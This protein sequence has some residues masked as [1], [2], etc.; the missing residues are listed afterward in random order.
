MPLCDTKMWYALS[1]PMCILSMTN[2]SA[3]ELVTVPPPLSPLTSTRTQHCPPRVC[4]L[5]YSYH[6]DTV[7][8]PGDLLLNPCHTHTHTEHGQ[9]RLYNSCPAHSFIH[10]L[11]DFRKISK[12][13]DSH[14]HCNDFIYSDSKNITW[15]DLPSGELKKGCY[16][17][18]CWWS[19]FGSASP[20]TIRSE[21]GTTRSW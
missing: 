7:I 8:I 4:I 2:I 10:T 19:S 6:W 18:D 14:S 5:G 17:E 3:A 21:A 9:W 16:W 1:C 20:S 12:D 15:K 13:Q 11:R